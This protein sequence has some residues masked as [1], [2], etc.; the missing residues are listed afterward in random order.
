MRVLHVLYS[1]IYTGAEKVAAQI[2]QSFSGQVDMAY[3]SLEDATVR[4]ILEDQG[5]TFLSYPDLTPK[6]LKQVI[7]SYQPDV[8]HAH[9]MRTSFVAAL[10]CG[11]IPLVSHIHNNAYDSRGLSLK[12]IAYLIAGFRA[13]RILWVSRSS[14][15]GYFFHKLFAKKSQVLYNIIDAQQIYDMADRDREHY[16]FDLIYLGRLTYQK[17]PQRLMRLCARLK[18]IRPDVKLAVVGAGE[19][20]EETK[21]L[22]AQ[23]SLEDN[24]QFMGFQ[25][26]PMKMLSDSRCLVLTSRWEGTPMCALEAM[27]LGTPVVSTP[28]DGMMD[29]IRSGENGY[30]SD[31][32]EE[33]AKSIE[34][35]LANPAH[36]ESLS[37]KARE[38]FARINDQDAYKA[39]IGACYGENRE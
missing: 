16:A 30:L 34:A 24:V 10:C 5:I 32:D 17:D 2:I 19:L 21:A 20:E 29:L 14:Y 31:D 38:D 22:C 6:Y 7:D 35:I 39:A 9:D 3:C 1:T 11:S 18:E 15:E 26:N 37:R 23:L 13:R 36:R 33:L 28:T 25:S 8:I 12:S 27:A 4:K